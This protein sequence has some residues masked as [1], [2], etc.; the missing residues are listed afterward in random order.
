VERPAAESGPLVFLTS[1]DFAER[2]LARRLITLTRRTHPLHPIRVD[3]ALAW[4][5]EKSGL[6]FDPRQRD[7]VKA[8]LENKTLIITGGPGV[9][10]TTLVRAILNIFR[11]RRKKT[12]LCAPTGRAAK[13]LQESCGCP[14]KTIHRTLIYDPQTHD[15]KYNAE[16][17]LDADLVVVDEVS[18][19]DVTLAWQLVRAVPAHA[20]LVLVGDAD[21]LPSVGPGRVLGDLIESGVLPV[22]RLNHIFRQA[23]ASQIVTNAHR[24]NAGEMPELPPAGAAADTAAPRDFFFFDA[25]DPARA[26][27]Q[28]VRLVRAAIPQKFRLDPWRD[29]QVLTPMQRG[30]LGARNLNVLL[31][32]ALNHSPDEGI[33]RFGARYRTGDKVMQVMNNYDKDVYNGDIGRI[34]RIHSAERE[35]VVRF[36]DRLVKY[37][38]LELDELAPAYA[39]TIH[40]S[41]GSEYPCVVIPLHTQHFVLLER[42][43]VYT[44]IT[45]GKKLVVLVGTR[46]ALALAVKRAHSARRVTLLPERLRREQEGLLTRFTDAPPAAGD[47]P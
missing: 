20:A 14:A 40:K 1:L 18:M 19:L 29:I 27:A 38:L 30:E 44:A 12:L 47:S 16:R 5:E 43:L 42:N 13:R 35:L 10:K 34:E 15:F 41:Q 28:V 2:E 39:I 23:A 9:G 4:A 21:Q 36:D 45:R 37:D 31:Q 26:A 46:K 17:S 22:A 25:E 3:A 24:I 7:A 6:T 32:Q 8:A 11:A 33:E